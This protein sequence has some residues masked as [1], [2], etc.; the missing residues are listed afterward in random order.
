MKMS[1][2]LWNLSALHISNWNFMQSG[3]FVHNILLAGAR[4]SF[5]VLYKE[6][7]LAYNAT[8]TEVALA[9]TVQTVVISIVGKILPIF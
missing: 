4:R 1:F 7:M 3:A 5:G 2:P 6:F 8:A 9:M